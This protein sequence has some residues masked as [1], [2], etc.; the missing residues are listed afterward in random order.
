MRDFVI[1]LAMGLSID[2]LYFLSQ[3]SVFYWFENTN[4]D[5]ELGTLKH[6]I[7][8]PQI[9]SFPAYNKHLPK[10]HVTAIQN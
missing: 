1:F 6:L 7:F 4:S 5:A 3:V 2:V 8:S 9:G 10:E